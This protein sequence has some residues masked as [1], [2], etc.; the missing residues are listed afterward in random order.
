VANIVMLGFLAAV[1]EVVG[2]D[3]LKKTILASV[4]RGTEELNASAFERG[5]QYGE[6]ARGRR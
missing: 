3:S 1:T 2:H 6:E 4:P 5:Y